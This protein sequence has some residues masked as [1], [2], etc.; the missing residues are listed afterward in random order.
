M[1]KKYT[2]PVCGYKGLEEPP[3]INVDVSMAH[4]IF[5]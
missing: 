5:K 4:A 1:E 2:C 3:S